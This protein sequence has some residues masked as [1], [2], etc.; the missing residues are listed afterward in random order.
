[1]SRNTY[2]YVADTIVYQCGYDITAYL[3]TPPSNGSFFESHIKGNF[4]L[5]VSLF[6]LSFVLGTT[7]TS[8]EASMQS[9]TLKLYFLI[10]SLI[11]LL[12]II[13]KYNMNKV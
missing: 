8:E 11:F 1:M 6:A 5:T 9:Q 12:L 2:Q 4:D 13:I 7:S 10:S 3:A